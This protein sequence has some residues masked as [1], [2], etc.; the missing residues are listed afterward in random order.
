M[1]DVQRCRIFS[2][3]KMFVTYIFH[4]GRAGRVPLTPLRGVRGS[5][6]LRGVRGS[7]G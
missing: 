6:K 5:E 7:V 2:A 3:E 1:A 4:R